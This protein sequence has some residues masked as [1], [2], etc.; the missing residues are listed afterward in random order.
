MGNSTLFRAYDAFNAVGLGNPTSEFNLPHLMLL[1]DAMK[2]VPVLYEL[3]LKE[4]TY[5][6][7]VSWETEVQMTQAL[8]QYDLNP[9]DLQRV[10]VVK[11]YG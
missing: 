4:Y 5:G 7:M 1:L 10:T 8:L 11:I 9:V 3:D 2:V 6:L